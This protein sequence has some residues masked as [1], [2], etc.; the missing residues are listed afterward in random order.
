M[1]LAPLVSIDVASECLNRCGNTRASTPALAAA[2]AALTIAAYGGIRVSLGRLLL[3]AASL[4]AFGGLIEILQLFVPGRSCEWEDL[5]ADSIGIALGM[6]VA[7]AL[8]RVL[9]RNSRPGP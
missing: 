1:G 6:V 4:L 8:F 2:F 3:L 7:A 5:F 9:R